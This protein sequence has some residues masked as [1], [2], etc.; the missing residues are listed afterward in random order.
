[1]IARLPMKFDSIG[2]GFLQKN[3]QG[4]YHPGVDLN[5]GTGN[6]DLG[7]PVYPMANGKV[8]YAQNA[9]AGW[10]NLIVIFHEQ[11]GVWTRYAHLN[12]ILCKEGDDVNMAS[13]I[14]ECGKTGSPSYTA[15]CHFEVIIKKLAHWTQYT[16]GWSKEK[17]LKYYADPIVFVENIISKYEEVLQKAMQLTS[18]AYTELEKAL[19]EIPGVRPSQVLLNKSNTSLRFFFT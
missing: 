14:G 7:D 13:K 8:V 10:G 3:A 9:G 6:Q 18:D 16:T 4:Q 17:C 1:M 5:R 12:K 19:S 11:Y 15:H 2:Y